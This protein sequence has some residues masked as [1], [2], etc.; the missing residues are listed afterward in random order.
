MFSLQRLSQA[1]A[2]LCLALESQN[3]VVKS[4]KSQPRTVRLTQQIHDQLPTDDAAVTPKDE[5]VVPGA[6]GSL[7]AQCLCGSE[8]MH[9]QANKA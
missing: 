8:Q 2:F 1:F 7:V 3:Q 4:L 9:C 6:L 5:T